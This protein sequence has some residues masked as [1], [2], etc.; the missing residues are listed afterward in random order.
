MLGKFF[1]FQLVVKP[2]SKP[3]IVMFTLRKSTSKCKTDG[4]AMW[5]MNSDH[6]KHV[7]QSLAQKMVTSCERYELLSQ[8][9]YSHKFSS[10]FMGLFWESRGWKRQ[11]IVISG[12]EDSTR[13]SKLWD[14]LVRHAKLFSPPQ[15]LYHCIPGFGQTHQGDASMW[16]LQVHSL[17][18]HFLLPSMLILSGQRCHDVIYNVTEDHWC[19]EVDVWMPWFTGTVG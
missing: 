13:T 14:S 6:T 11:L 2:Y 12:G 9:A 8:R 15:P 7:R 10:P 5:M 16:S 19:T 3:L 18:N 17:A 4:Q 1:A